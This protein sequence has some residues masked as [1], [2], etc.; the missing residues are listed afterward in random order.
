MRI[1]DWSSDVCSSDLHKYKIA[2]FR[3]G[4]LF[5]C[6]HT[7]QW[8]NNSFKLLSGLRTFKDQFAHGLAVER[9]RGRNDIG[10]E[11][12][13]YGFDRRAARR[14]QHVGDDK[15]GRAPW[16]EGCVSPCRSRWA[17]TESK[18]KK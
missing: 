11:L 9:A 4:S 7:Y 14:G 13:A 5:L 2:S 8:M 10:A 12:M 3:H 16:R 17:P 6:N 1:S 15:V 18:K